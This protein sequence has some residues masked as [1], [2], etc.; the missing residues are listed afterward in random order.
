[1]L[2]IEEAK[3]ILKYYGFTSN[4]VEPTLYQN[5]KDVGIFATF[6][7]KY[8]HLSRFIK[9]NN[10]EQTKRFLDVYLWYRKNSKDNAVTVEFDDYEKLDPIIKFYKNNIEVTSSNLTDIKYSNSK[11]E[12][13][14]IDTSSEDNSALLNIIFDKARNILKEIDKFQNDLEDLVLEYKEKLKE[15]NKRTLEN[16][17]EKI[18]ITRLNTDKYYD[19]INKIFVANNN[20]Q[21]NNFEEYFAKAL[22]LLEEVSLNETYFENLYMYEY[23]KEQIKILDIKLELYNK[24]IKEVN[25]EKNKIFKN[26]KNIITFN[27]Y[28]IKCN[29]EE[30]NI[31]KDEIIFNKK[32]DLEKDLIELKN[33]STEELKLIYKIIIP[34]KKE[35]IV[36]ENTIVD[37]DS[38][39]YYFMSLTKEERNNIL[40]LSS[41]LKDLINLI[42]SIEE[43]NKMNVIINEKYYKNKFKEMYELLSNKDNY[44]ASRKYL[45]FLKLDSL[46]DFIESLIKF[47]ENL[48]ITPFALPV[49]TILK[50]KMGVFLKE[51]YINA[52]I[53]NNYPINSKGD[54]NYCISVPMVLIHGYYSPY[55][56][57]FDEYDILN[58]QE[59]DNIITFNIKGLKLTDKMEQ[60][61]N[62][63]MLKKRNEN[64]TFELFNEK[65]YINSK[66]ENG[67]TYE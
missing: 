41:P 3:D 8:G 18:K 45:K 54:N 43:K 16:K 66:I 39:N 53:T 50:Y 22:K 63:Y 36:E 48:N 61:V 60:K 42:N 19:E 44:A 12:E 13:L 6:K 26:K 33:N 51:G 30:K 25:A 2:S 11:V 23:Y 57:K 65:T 40:V 59:N 4:S 21:E 38:L 28:I 10:Q 46:E 5:K 62:N 29:I 17:E 32:T 9:F 24:Y 55:I 49:K 27:E 20:D 1:M 7:T 14:I 37:V 47:I 35:E 67:D 31:S 34:E 52:S 56:L 15:L 58:V 64:V